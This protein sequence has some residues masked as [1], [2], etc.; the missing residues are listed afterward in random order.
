MHL[1]AW[2]EHSNRD[3]QKEQSRVEIWHDYI[4]E[5]GSGGEPG[6]FIVQQWQHHNQVEKT[7]AQT[8]QVREATQ[9][10]Y[11]IEDDPEEDKAG[12]VSLLFRCWEDDMESNQLE[13]HR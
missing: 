8:S 3:H 13:Y 4:Q 9:D 10:L 5:T 1:V 6:L 12:V 11:R 7:V 2:L